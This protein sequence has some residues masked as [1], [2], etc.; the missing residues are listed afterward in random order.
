MPARREPFSFD[1]IY[2]GWWKA[3]VLA[4][5][6]AAVARSGSSH[7]LV[8]LNHVRLV[9]ADLFRRFGDPRVNVSR[10]GGDSRVPDSKST[11]LIH[12]IHPFF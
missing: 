7:P 9:N 5:A 8:R 10:R 12:C 1:Q 6:K 11:V 3:N 2:G 4:D